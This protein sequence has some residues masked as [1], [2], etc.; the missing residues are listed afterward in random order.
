MS[1]LNY[2]PVK[3][4]F[5]VIACLFVEKVEANHK[6][7][8]QKIPIEYDAYIAWLKIIMLDCVQYVGKTGTPNQ[9]RF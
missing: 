6:S 4:A 3:L 9:K 2:C 7:W 8:K 5:Q 1:R